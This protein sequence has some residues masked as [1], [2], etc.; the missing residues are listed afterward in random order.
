MRV[1][2]A[3]VSASLFAVLRVPPAEDVATLFDRE[4]GDP[5]PHGQA[6]AFGNLPRIAG[7]TAFEVG[8]HR[9]V[10]D[11]DDLLEMR[12]HHVDADRIVRI[13]LRPRVAGRRRGQRLE[14]E[15]LQGHR[16]ADIEGVW[17][18]E[19]AAL[20]QLPPAFAQAPI[21]PMPIRQS[22]PISRISSISASPT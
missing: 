4:P 13:G 11:A 9:H 3:R 10:C 6:D 7:E 15:M 22:P 8:I 21:T 5:G 18:D 14:A 1:S 16:A 2:A 12:Q 20:V 17:N 19:A